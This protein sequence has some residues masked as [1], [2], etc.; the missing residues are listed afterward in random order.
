MVTQPLS[1]QQINS[2]SETVGDMVIDWDVPIT[3]DDGIVI[4]ADVFR[5]RE[6][7]RYP[8]LFSYG[9]YAKGLTF[10][11]GFIRDQWRKLTAE[12]PE[13]ARGLERPL[14][15]L[16]GGRPGEVGA[17]RLRLRTAGL[18]RRGPVA[19]VAGPVRSAG[20]EDM[21]QCI[22]WA[23][24][25]PWSSG[26]VGMAGISYY[27]MNQWHVAALQPPHLAAICAWE[28]AADFYRDVH[29]SRRHPVH[30]LAVTGTTGRLEY[31]QHGRAS[32]GCA[33]R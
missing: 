27:A 22:E 11:D 17:G 26:K 8:A 7:D 16:G 5:P 10:Q 30:V 29:P 1:T 33:A 9:P 14:S 23:A 18:P 12:H 25:Q 6:E 4:R 13:V 31:V 28:G 2:R 19:G 3:M 24:Q 21:Y 15:E 32:A 20:D